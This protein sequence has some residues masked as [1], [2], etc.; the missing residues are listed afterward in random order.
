MNWYANYNIGV[1]KID[2]QHQKLAK[3]IRK[4]QHSLANGRFTPETGATLK[5]LVE[6]TKVH[7]ADEEA[8]MVDIN[9]EELDSHQ[10]LHKKL[11]SQVVDILLDLKKGKVIDAYELLDFL[12]NWLTKHIVHED[13][14]SVV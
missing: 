8:L 4:L 11:V 3:T 1:E 13:Q 2:E 6:Y 10:A 12:T 14:K 9:Y 5:F 7:F